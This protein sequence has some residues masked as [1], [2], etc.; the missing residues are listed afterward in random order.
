MQDGTYLGK[1]TAIYKTAKGSYEGKVTVE[2]GKLV[3]VVLTKCAHDSG[4][5]RGKIA[6]DKMIKAN[7]IY[8]DG[9][10]GAT[11]V[12]LVENALTTLTQSK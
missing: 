10:S 3:K 5:S 12:G 1:Y 6:Y 9:I 7:D 4:P 8:V 11:W 2:S